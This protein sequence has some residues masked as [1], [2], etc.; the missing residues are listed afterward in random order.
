MWCRRSFVVAF[1]GCLMAGPLFCAA[2]R[3]QS[4]WAGAA[5]LAGPEGRR[6]G[7]PG[8]DMRGRDS[9]LSITF[10]D[11]TT[12]TLT[13]NAR[14][15]INDFVYRATAR[16]PAL[17]NVA[18]GTGSLVASQTSNMKISTPKFNARHPRRAGVV[19]IPEGGDDHARIN[20][21]YPDANGSVGRI[22]VFNLDGAFRVV[23][24]L[25]RL[26]HPLGRT[27]ALSSDFVSNLPAGGRPRPQCRAAAFL[28][29]QY[30]LQMIN[31]RRQLRQ[32]APDGGRT[33]QKQPALPKRDPLCKSKISGHCSLSPSCRESR[34]LQ[35]RT[36]RPSVPGGP[37]PVRAAAAAARPP[38][39]G[40]GP[41]RA[42]LRS[43]PTVAY[44]NTVRG[45]CSCRMI[46]QSA[47]RPRAVTLHCRLPG[48]I[49]PLIVS[50]VNC[51]MIR[52]G[53]RPRIVI[54]GSTCRPAGLGRG[55]VRQSPDAAL[56][57]RAR[58]RRPP[59]RR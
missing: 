6:S 30:H 27:F 14:V 37:E 17:F 57:P 56:S 52:Q 49:E 29:A 10:D 31:Q 59:G 24:R 26:R 2:S 50:L 11:E 41:P 3:G 9:T 39:H 36:R 46:D 20:S 28:H 15:A 12:F 43:L 16:V 7:L 54:V 8:R 38:G 13:A 19:E 21:F 53:V 18:R 47:V 25:D 1:M 55:A 44:S 42:L 51:A 48:H 22:E 35:P 33:P 45:N 4:R 58:I 40:H 23:A 5:Q 32:P 34:Q